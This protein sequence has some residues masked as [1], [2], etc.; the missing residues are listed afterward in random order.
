TF[1][2]GHG[3][4]YAS[5][6]SSSPSK[7]VRPRSKG[8]PCY[9]GGEPPNVKRLC[10]LRYNFRFPFGGMSV[11]MELKSEALERVLEALSPVL[12]AELD[13]VVAETRQELEQQFQIRL[14]EAVRDAEAAT[15]AEADGQLARAVANAQDT[16]R[17]EVTAQLEQKFQ[18]SLA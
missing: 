1:L 15:K 16:T 13:R 18:T 4:R 6:T 5:R 7:P 14:Q 3:P 10:L 8:L 11:S 2:R 12:V 17:K 9:I